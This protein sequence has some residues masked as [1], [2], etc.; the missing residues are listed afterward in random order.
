MKRKDLVLVGAGGFGRE[1]LWQLGEIDN[2][3]GQYNILGFV[4]DAP[5]FKGKTINGLPVLG[6]IRWLS[7][8]PKEICALICV[9]NPKA[10]KGIYNRI[11]QNPNISFPTI[12]AKNVQCSDLVKFG[13]GCIV[14]LSSVLTVNIVIG[15]FVIINLD[16][17]IG[18]DAV[19]DDFVT[20][21][22]SVN[23][24]GNVYIGACS[25]IGTGANIIQ[26]KNIGENAIIGA[27]AVVV[28]DIPPDCTA[29]GVPA[30]RRAEVCLNC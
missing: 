16:C 7:S 22:P 12:M 6:D 13:Q 15:E 20:L 28:N 24:S 21:H 2:C 5:E 30:K 25:E 8:Y 1:V 9:G 19:L 27:G 4:D 17:T 26:G 23:V 3:A 14:C 29:V 18:H 10:R 11:R